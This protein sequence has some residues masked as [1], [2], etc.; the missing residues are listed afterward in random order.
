[1]S[2]LQMVSRLIA[3][4]RTAPGRISRVWRRERYNQHSSSHLAHHQ[5]VRRR[6]GRIEERVRLPHFVDVVEAEHCVLEE[7]SDLVVDLEGII[8]VEDVDVE[9]AHHPGRLYY[10][11]IQL[12]RSP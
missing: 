1:M 12:A 4:D 6:F 7:V 2:L 5:P 9:E 3:A 11:R 10:N 8:V